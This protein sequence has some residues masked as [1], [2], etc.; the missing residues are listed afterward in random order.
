MDINSISGAV[1][2]PAIRVNSELGA[3]LLASTYEACL[4]HEL[5][6]RNIQVQN[7]LM[8][9]VIYKQAKIDA[10]YR[11]DLLVAKEVIVELKAVEQLLPIHD[12]QLLTY[13]KL[14]QKKA[15]LLINFNGSVAKSGS[16]G[17]SGELLLK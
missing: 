5:Q 7:Q 2:D 11:I 9:P 3:G 6:S 8:L 15:G 4:M 12:A 10:G 13:L 17:S 14:S 1:V 16:T